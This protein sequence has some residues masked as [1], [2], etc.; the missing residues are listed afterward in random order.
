MISDIQIIETIGSVEMENEWLRQRVTE[1]EWALAASQQREQAL[2]ERE[3]RLTF[4]LEGSRDGLW[5]WDIATG[6][7]YFSSRWHEMLGYQP[8]DVPGHVSSW[9]Q[10]VH[11]DDRPYV[12]EV[13]QPH[14]DGQTPAYETE[15]RCR[16][17]DGQW[18]W[19]LDR[20]KVIV[21]DKAGKPLRMVGT[22]TDVTERKQLEEE[23]LATQARLWHIIAS[24]PAIIYTCRASGDFGAT[25]IS[26]NVTSVFGYTG[27]QFTDNPT[28]WADHIHPDDAPTVFANL[29]HLF[30]H[31]HH[32][33][34]YRFRHA[35]GRYRWV[36]DQLRLISAD[37]GGPIEII[38]S[39]QD[40]TE[41][42]QLEEDLRITNQR[43]ESSFAATPLATIEFD[44]AGIITRWNPSAERIFGWTADEALGQELLPLVVPGIAMEQVEAV[45][46]SLFSDHIVNNRNDNLTKDGRIITCQW[47][48]TILRDEHG[49]VTGIL[50]Q[51]EDVTEQVRQEQAMRESEQLLHTLLNTIPIPIFY[52]DANSIYLGCNQAFATQIVGKPQAEIIGKTVYQIFTQDEASVYDNADQKLF[53][54]GGAQAY[55]KEMTYA[56]GTSHTI[57]FHKSVF[58]GSN[59]TAGG[60]VGAILDITEHKQAEFE[61][62]KFQEQL[63][64]AQ[65]L[66]L[67]ELS[68][69]L[70]PIADNVVIMPLVGSIDT[71]RAQQVLESLLDGVAAHHAE[72]VI[73]DITG[74]Q[75]VD[76][77]VANAF[78]RAA[79]AVKL[80][81]AHIIMTGIKPQIAQTLVQLG[82]DLRGI[83]TRGTL[84]AGIAAA[85]TP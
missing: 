55:E 54:Q 12:M 22:H 63:I 82:V 58:T 81:G 76:T 70:I 14:L 80:L 53:Q 78:I 85:L 25:F 32:T 66:A 37:Q 23:L 84:Q 71:Q 59:S 61:R 30:E 48:N 29:A 50:A 4:A 57:I 73:L 69:P 9:A 10:I 36:H 8:G 44:T 2:G 79:Q 18:K 21:R 46:N 11:P 39:W 68:T 3:E 83:T 19:I 35:D 15:H 41:R 60:I 77:Q 64:E 40:I 42:K 17:K 72:T 49:Q 27:E 33:H 38:G 1:L 5:D 74:V 34:E 47:Y 26:D 65:R 56:D 7:V 20:G 51:T 16:T 45:R 62:T 67:R 52:K 24:S 31:G 75:V 43:L 13:L 28:F 6:K